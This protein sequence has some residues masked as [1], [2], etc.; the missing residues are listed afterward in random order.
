MTVKREFMRTVLEFLQAVGHISS[1][2]SSGGSDRHDYEWSF[3]TKRSWPSK[4]RLPGRQQHEHF[5]STA[6]HR[7]VLHL[8]RC[9]KMPV[10]IRGITLGQASTPGSAPRSW[11]DASASMV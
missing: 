5:R 8:G 4:P 1:W 9:A 11:P 6:E 2:T 3:A 7:R 10:Q